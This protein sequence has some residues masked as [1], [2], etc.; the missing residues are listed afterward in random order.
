MKKVLVIL[1]LVVMLVSVC[2]CNYVPSSRFMS[3]SKANS[4]EEKYGKPQAVLTIN[5]EKENKE[6]KIEITYDLLLSQA[7]LAVIRFI[8]LANE[9]FYNNTVFDTYN[10]NYNY[11]VMGRY[12]Y[13][14]SAKEEGTMKFFVNKSDVTF[15][16]EFK[17]NNY[18]EPD[19]GYA[20]FKIFSL[21]MYHDEYVDE[22]TTNF[23]TANGTLIFATESESL[24]S[25][26]YAVFAHMKTVSFDGGTPMSRIPSEVRNHLTSF[27]ST[28]SNRK[29]YT[30]ETEETTVPYFT[31][32]NETVTIQVKIIGDWSQ[33]PKIGKR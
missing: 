14:E 32:M 7:P 27:T 11:I 17:N 24:K 26:N 13:K 1:V 21:A 30:D 16:G 20:E 9:G 8:E 22:T 12:A 29:V 3:R 33:L 10:K 25:T 31:M 18:P 4:L 2:A 23:D 6:H 5:Y 19:A 15:K 28:T